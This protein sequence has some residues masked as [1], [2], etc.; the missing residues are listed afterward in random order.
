[1]MVGQKKV[2]M[3]DKI[4]KSSVKGKEDMKIKNDIMKDKK[5]PMKY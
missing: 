2:V 1:M 3:K 5:D 4:R